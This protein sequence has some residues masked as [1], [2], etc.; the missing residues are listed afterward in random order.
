[1]PRN[2]KQR[3]RKKS[4]NRHLLSKTCVTDAAAD[5]NTKQNEFLK[6]YVNLVQQRSLIEVALACLFQK[7]PSV[8]IM[9]G[10]TSRQQ[11]TQQLPTP[12]QAQKVLE[13]HDE[14][15]VTPKTLPPRRKKR[16]SDIPVPT[17]KSGSLLLIS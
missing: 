17:L 8:K 5:S 4:K 6:D 1:M 2:A 9:G 12:P 11:L 14:V 15:P 16:T 7:F 13:N 3:N 10:S